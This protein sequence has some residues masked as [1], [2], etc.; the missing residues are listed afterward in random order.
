MINVNAENWKIQYISDLGTI[1]SGSTPS[2]HNQ[3]FW[4]G[5]IAW[6]TPN[7]L[8]EIK[9]LFIHSSERKITIAGLQSCSAKLLPAK[10]LVISSRAPIGYLALPTTNFCTNQGCKSIVFNPEQ[11]PEF[12]YYNLL[13]RVKLIKEK[14][15][16]TTFSEISKAALSKIKIPVPLSISTQ[17]KIAEVLSKIDKAI[18]QTETLIAKYKRIKTGLMQDLLTR[19]IDEHGQLRDPSTHKFKRSPL[20][21]IPDEWDIF[22]LENVTLK[23][24]SGSRFWASYYS[25]EGAKFIRIGNLTREH[26]NL[27]LDNVQYVT[28]PLSSE[29]KRTLLKTGDLLV[30]VTADLGIIGVVPENFGE[31]YINQHIALI[32]LDQDRVNPW[33]LG[34]FLAGHTAQ[35]SIPQLNESGA[36]AGLNL[37]TVANLL[38]TVPRKLEEQNRVAKILKTIDDKL[39]ILYQSCEKLNFIKLG[40]MQD[41]LTGKTS[42]KPL[43]TNHECI[44]KS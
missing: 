7:D 29:A 39:V 21:M 27:R 3:D 37:P 8:S 19:G 17:S 38:I 43:L 25:D 4:N 30:S 23:I 6:I 28:P 35:Q 20:G 42:V 33:W 1:Y 5:D 11:D 13:F 24:T 41:L 32:T 15:E 16:G 2:T 9:S 44:P 31:A 12:H 14:G 18:A 36:K 10:S 26:I 22:R 34:N 40:L